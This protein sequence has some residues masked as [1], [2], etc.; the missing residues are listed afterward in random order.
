MRNEER[1]ASGK[2]QL[3]MRNLAAHPPISG[4][5]FLCAGIVW[6]DE[7][8]FDYLLDPAKYIKVRIPLLKSFWWGALLYTTDQAHA[9]S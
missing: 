9:P 1:R 8:L 5:M 2:K 3:F 6:N 4:P 7:T